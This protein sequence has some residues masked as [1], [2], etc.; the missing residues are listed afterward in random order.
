LG[1]CDALVRNGF[2]VARFDNRDS[3]QSTHLDW[4]GT[5]DRRRVCRRPDNAPYRLEDM[6]DDAAAVLDAL[7]WRLAHIVGHWMGHDRPNPCDP[8]PPIGCDR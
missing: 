3:G 8:T 4:A 2:Q 1:L 7:G 6:A 5:P